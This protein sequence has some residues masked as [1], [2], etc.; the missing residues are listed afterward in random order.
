M[1]LSRKN[2]I[3]RMG[4]ARSGSRRVPAV[5][6]VGSSFERTHR[7]LS[8]LE[9]DAALGQDAQHKPCRV[10][11]HGHGTGPPP[12]LPPSRPLVPRTRTPCSRSSTSARITKAS[13]GPTR[14][15]G[16]PPSKPS[17]ACFAA[18]GAAYDASASRRAP[19]MHSSPD[20]GPPFNAARVRTAG[21]HGAQ[22]GLRKASLPFAPSL[23]RRQPPRDWQLDFARPGRPS[24]G[25]LLPTAAREL[26]SPTVRK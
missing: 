7:T 24:P 26:P 5:S 25:V 13:E 18:A 2:L 8:S 19:V 3:C 22:S 17:Q 20:A 16:P 9:L 6:W 4:Q 11:D 10:L 12:R 15:C 1:A 14:R 21:S 23:R